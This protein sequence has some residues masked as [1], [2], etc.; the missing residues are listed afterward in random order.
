MK[1]MISIII[2]II[3]LLGVTNS[4]HAQKKSPALALGFSIGV[5]VLSLFT[6]P[7]IIMGLTVAPSL[8]HMYAGQWG[9]AQLFTGLRTTA[10]LVAA[11]CEFPDTASGNMGFFYIG[12]G[13]WGVTT[14]IDWCMV[15]SSV[16]KYNER[17]QLQPEINLNDGT[18]GI[19]ISY[20]F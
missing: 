20:R 3:L 18:Y 15:P 10:L 12:L 4:L 8:G 9:R 17:F 2:N 11:L 16:E 14:L 6:G 7:G 1:T 19:G 13:M 5:P